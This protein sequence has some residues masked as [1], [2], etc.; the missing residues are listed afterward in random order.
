MT[1]NPYKT[2]IIKSRDNEYIASKKWMCE[3]SKT[4]A[5]YWIVHCNVQECRICGKKV[6]LYVHK[7]NSKLHNR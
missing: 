2:N 6:N 3:Y 4:G 1:L 7:S 5:H